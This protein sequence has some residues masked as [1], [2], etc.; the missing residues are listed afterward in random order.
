M[1]TT[2]IINRDREMEEQQAVFSLG[3]KGTPLMDSYFSWVAGLMTIGP[4]PA[5]LCLLTVRK[6]KIKK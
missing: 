6:K 5:L 1:L 2:I 3:R 4:P